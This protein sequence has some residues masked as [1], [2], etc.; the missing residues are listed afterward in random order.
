MQSVWPRPAKK[1]WN[2]RATRSGPVRQDVFVIEPKYA[3]L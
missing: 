3:W 1:A 2:A